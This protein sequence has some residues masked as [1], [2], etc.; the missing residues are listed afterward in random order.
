MRHKIPQPATM[1]IAAV[2][3]FLLCLS[4][5][6]TVKAQDLVYAKGFSN[7]TPQG[8]NAESR[9]IAV[10]AAGNKYVLGRFQNSTDFDPGAGVQDL[11]SAGGYDIYFA[12]YD[13]ANNYV[14][15]K[16]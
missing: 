15:A 4:L 6:Q 12:K 8:G 11:V 10:D 16:R 14:W 13:A 7:S 5:F 9:A 3:F 2:Q 1:R